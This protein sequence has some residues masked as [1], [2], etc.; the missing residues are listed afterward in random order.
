MKKKKHKAKLDH[1]RSLLHKMDLNFFN[2]S[3]KKDLEK[4]FKADYFKSS[5]VLLR[6]SFLLGIFYFSVFTLLDSYAFPEVKTQLHMIRFL[7]VCPVILVVLMLSYLKSFHKFW[8]LAASIDIIISGAAIVFMMIIIPS[9][10]SV[11]YYTGIILVLIYNYM[12]IR[13]RFIWATI[14]GFILILLYLLSTNFFPAEL[15][16]ELNINFFF[17]LSANLLG[18]FGG[19]VLEYYTRKEFYFR[20]LLEKERRSIEYDNTKLEAMVNKKTRELQDDI[21]KR[22]EAEKALRESEQKYRFLADN[23]VDVIWQMDLR[24][25]FTYV[26]PSISKLTGH[27]QKEWTGS[28]LSEHATRREFIKMAKIALGSIKKYKNFKHVIFE[29]KMLRK[30]GSTVPVEIN[31]TLIYN[32]QGFPVGLQGS[33]RDISERIQADE[34]IQR[35]LEEKNILIK[36]L[37]HRTKNNMQVVASLIKIKIR[38]FKES[39]LSHELKE[40]NSKIVSL[41]LVHEQLYRSHDLSSLDLDIYLKELVKRL[42]S[43]YNA[44]DNVKF[45][46]ELD[47]VKVS[48]D[49]ASPLGL[50]VTELISNTFKHA[51]PENRQ[52]TVKLSLYMDT[53]GMIVIEIKD[54][55]VGTPPGMDL[56]KLDSLGL[57][58]AINLLEYQMKG[59]IDYENDAGLKWILKFNDKLNVKRI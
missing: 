16:R 46:F 3:F 23:S 32:E 56:R 45:I 48:I 24:L 44:Y 42:G 15:T 6:V 29:A 55:G 26:S 49:T 12:L 53:D 5:L 1:S 30:D 18:M 39:A 36:E 11:I 58:N 54:D 34:N 14:N 13:L 51:F 31:G 37:Y 40:I 21:R 25:K 27:T 59:I 20:Q 2:L 22:K 50:V 47:N 7:I 41:A 17:L 19:Y 43:S 35:S 38:Q 52:G 9:E 28:Y 4:K 8:Q 33:T 10:D 57:Y